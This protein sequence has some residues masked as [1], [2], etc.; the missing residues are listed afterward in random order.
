MTGMRLANFGGMIPLMSSRLLPDNMAS[1][2]VNGYFR[3][4]EIRGVR[5]PV[6]L[7]TF[8]P[9]PAYAKA[10][11]IPDPSAPATPVWFG[12]TSAYAHLS[13]NPLVNDTFNRFMWV[14]GNQPGTPAAMKQN[15]LA[16]IKDE[17]PAILLGVPAPTAAPTLVPTGGTVLT[18]TRAYVYTY[19]NLF[20]EEGPPSPAVT[21]S[22]FSDATWTLG[23]MVNPAF[24]T[25]RGITHSRIYRTISGTLGT[26]FYRV[27]TV[28][29][30]TASYADT[31]LSSVVAGEGLV[32]ESTTWEPPENVEGFVEMPNGFFAAWSGKDLFFSEPFRPWAWP[33]QYTVAVASRIIACGVI[34]QTLVVLTESAPVLYIGSNPA[35]MSAVKS[36]LIEPCIAARSVAQT[37][38]GVYYASHNGLA[39]VTHNGSALVTREIISHDEWTVD[40]TPRIAAAVG[41]DSQYLAFDSNGS[42]FILDPRSV[43]SSVTLLANMAPVDNVWSD[44]WTS[45]AHM[46]AGNVVYLWGSPAASFVTAEWIS[47]DFHFPKPV[48]MGAV[49]VYFDPRYANDS[50]TSDFFTEPPALQ[51]SPWSDQSSIINYNRINGCAVN[52]AP[53]WGDAPPD[54]PSAAVWPYWYGVEAGAV[55][56]DLPE[57]AACLMSVFANN[58][59]VWQA[60]VTNGVAHR[61]P[62][63]FKSDLWRV[64]V[65]TRVPVL[66]IQMAETAKELA[67]V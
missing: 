26:L 20:G 65:K 37:P 27:A 8:D 43:Q 50:A 33:P 4:G 5:E 54:N 13:P 63:G 32:M 15:S 46:I 6:V 14:D 53:T 44:R 59:L 49:V 45:E 11:R 12:L 61:L 48:N 36:A 23:T 10:I 67:S 55:P 17:D 34:D 41:F 1:A 57:G 19:V 39:L 60:Y 52:A 21:A 64:Q 24:A 42:G 31:R 16:R 29:V 58:A 35:A 3:G 22:A 56:F 47:K 2:A 51:G 28:T 25:D 38:E 9:S 18:E 30:A 40:F 66:S 62:S 7:H